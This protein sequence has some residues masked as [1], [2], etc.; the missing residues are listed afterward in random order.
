MLHRNKRPDDIHYGKYNG[1]GG[2]VEAH[3][4]VV[5]GA[6]RE[7]PRR[8]GAVGLVARAARNRAVAGFGP[9]GQ[10]W[11]GIIFRADTYD[12][13]SHKGNAEGTLEWVPITALPTIPM[14]D[15]DHEWLPMVFDD[16]PRS[17]TA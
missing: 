10:D 7:S 1:L 16:D 14:W 8:V 12:G 6:R 15:S 2:K 4:D 17:S 9:D 13:A 3:E 11:F 5:T